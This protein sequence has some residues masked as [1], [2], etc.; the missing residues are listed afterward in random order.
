M[1]DLESYIEAINGAASPDDA[2]ARFSA[3]M[4]RHGYDRIAYS[5]VTDHPSIGLPRQ[6]GLATSYPEDWM[7]HYNARGY[8]EIDPVTRRVLTTRKPFFW[9]DVVADPSLSAPSARL[10]NEAAEAGVCD[11]IGLSLVGQTGEL[12]G[13]GL[14]RTGKDGDKSGGKDYQFLAG[15]YL[16]SVFFHETFREMLAAPI[17]VTITER[18]REVLCWAAEGKTDEEIARILSISANTVRFHWRKIFVKLDA[19]GRIY[20]IT[21]AIRLQLIVPSG[22]GT[23]YQN[24]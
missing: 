19:N 1:K 18:E 9:A 17:A 10:M 12:V 6:H 24:R 7:K 4:R 5:L 16:L 11:G 20:A 22:V 21:K 2:F 23:P 14:A 8:M 3:I 15:A 13:V